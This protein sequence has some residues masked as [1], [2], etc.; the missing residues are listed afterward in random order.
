MQFWKPPAQRGIS[1]NATAP[2]NQSGPQTSAPQPAAPVKLTA[3]KMPSIRVA[4]C[5]EPRRSI[6]VEVPQP[7]VVRPTGSDKTLLKH[8]RLGP[9]EVSATPKGFKIGKREVT[10]SAIEFVPQTSPAV[11]VE[12][13]QYRGTVRIHRSAGDLSTA[14]NVVP[15]EDYIASVVDSEMPAAFPEEA[16]KAQAVVART[17]ALYQMQVAPRGAIADVQSST[18][19]QK[20]LGYQYRDGSRRLAG[21]SDAS[22]K[23]AQ[24]TRGQVCWHQGKIFCTYYSAVCG[25]KTVLGTEVFSDAAPPLKSVTCNFCSEARLYRWKVEIS[26]ADFE[27]KSLQISSADLRL[28]LSDRGVASNQFTI[29]ERGKSF[30]ID[31]RGHGHGVGLCQWGARGQALAG[32]K[33]AEILQCYYPGMSLA[34]RVW[35]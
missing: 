9:T 32:K 27:R 29:T 26:K 34:T 5:D 15:L 4:L 30:V 6:T 10:A 14:V 23:I 31:G 33:Y 25:G 3:E 1:Q 8:D 22:R 12:G 2:A 16:R 21:E 13:S 24:A 18:R 28:L 19:S 7:F 20:Y 35:K 17:Y 11:W